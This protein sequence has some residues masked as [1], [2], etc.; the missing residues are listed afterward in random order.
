MNVI[1]SDFIKLEVLI[2]R[3]NEKT[4]ILIFYFISQLLKKSFVSDF[5]GILLY[6]AL[7]KSI[8]L[9]EDFR[10]DSNDRELRKI[11]SE[12]NSPKINPE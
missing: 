9:M 8:L 12:L 7:K 1:T 10:G 5:N 6:N 4:P 2:L 11:V 3:F